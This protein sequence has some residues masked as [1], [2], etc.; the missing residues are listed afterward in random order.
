MTTEELRAHARATGEGYIVD[1]LLRP[2][3]GLLLAPP[4]VGKT[5]LAID[6]SLNV[7]TGNPFLGHRV[8]RPGP[9][10][11]YSFEP[12]SNDLLS[13]L[14][15]YDAPSDLRIDWHLTPPGDGSFEDFAQH[16]RA[17]VR[18]HP[19]IVLVTVDM[20][21][22]LDR[23]VAAEASRRDTYAIQMRTV[24]RQYRALA[25]ELNVALVLLHHPNS[26]NPEM[27][28]GGNAIS[29][30]ADIIWTLQREPQAS[31]GSLTVTGRSLPEATLELDWDKTSGRWSQRQH[32]ETFST[33]LATATSRDLMGQAVDASVGPDW[34][35]RPQL[36]DAA[37]GALKAHGREAGPA[38]VESEVDDHLRARVKRKVFDRRA[39][40]PVAYRRSTPQGQPRVRGY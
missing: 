14:G 7:S 40:R 23:P 18:A 29:G 1:G 31:R 3:L 21:D 27:P 39:T 11:H 35:T 32:G 20:W 38:Y 4:K 2:G 26:N 12:T 28:S 25:Q 36:I 37:V 6:L 9:V 30:T 13:T 5:R 16:L 34:V 33:N 8:L 10:V 17:L 15:A 19:E 22:A 24:L